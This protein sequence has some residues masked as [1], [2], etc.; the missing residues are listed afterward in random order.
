V[1]VVLAVA[2]VVLAVEAAAVLAAPVA[3]GPRRLRLSRRSS[4]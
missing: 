2:A 3:V 4:Q 1:A